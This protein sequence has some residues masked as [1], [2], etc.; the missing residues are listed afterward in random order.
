[1]W[2]ADPELLWSVCRIQVCQKGLG[3]GHTLIIPGISEYGLS[4]LS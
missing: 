2:Y 3:L 4:S 1:V